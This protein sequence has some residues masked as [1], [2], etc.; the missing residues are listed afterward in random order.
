MPELPSRTLPVSLMEAESSP[1]A[2]LDLPSVKLSTSHTLEST[3]SISKAK[4]TD[5]IS[6]TELFQLLKRPTELYHPPNCLCQVS[7][8]PL[9]VYLLMLEMLWL[10]LSNL[11]S[12]LLDVQ[13]PTPTLVDLE[14]HSISLLLDSV[15]PSSSVVLMVLE[16]NF[17]SHSITVNTRQSVSI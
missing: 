6:P 9:L 15:I 1:S 4:P 14:V 3:L 8:M 5:A 17:E 2:L 7:R 13:V 12:K 11:L 16:P 10:T